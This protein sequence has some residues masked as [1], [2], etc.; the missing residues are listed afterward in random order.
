MLI[1]VVSNALKFT[2]K[3]YIAI[4]SSYDPEKEFLHVTVRDSGAGIAEADMPTLFTKFGKIHRTAEINAEGIG[5][6]LTI[7]KNLIT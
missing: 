7:V 3:G 6:G 4:T 2:K 5:L 1:N